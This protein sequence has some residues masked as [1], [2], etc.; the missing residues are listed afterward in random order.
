M[1]RLN[2][3]EYPVTT[4]KSYTHYRLNVRDNNG[5]NETQLAKWQLFEKKTPTG[6]EQIETEDKQVE[7]LYNLCGLPVDR[8]YKGIVISKGQ[9]RMAK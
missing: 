9:K 8:T 1:V 6:V 5:S 3:V 7:S 4:D 2:T